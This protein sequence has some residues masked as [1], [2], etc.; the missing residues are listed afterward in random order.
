M[1]KIKPYLN[2]DYFYN[3]T[4]SQIIQGDVHKC[5]SYIF[6]IVPQLLIS[7]R[8]K[9]NLGDENFKIKSGL[10]NGSFCNLASAASSLFR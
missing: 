1:N 9:F 6:Q 5:N 7:G 4:D 3:K 8:W 10:S 2:T